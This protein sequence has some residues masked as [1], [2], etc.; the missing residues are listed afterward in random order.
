MASIANT[1]GIPLRDL[2]PETERV[3]DELD[4][5]P[6]EDEPASLLSAIRD[7]PALTPQQRRALARS[8]PR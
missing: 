7:D 4:Q 5:D 2:R 8:T 3:D 1:L 6:E